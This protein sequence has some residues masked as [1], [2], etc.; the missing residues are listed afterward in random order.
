MEMV[1]GR[2]V[3]LAIP[4]SSFPFMKLFSHI[5][6][7]HFQGKNLF[8]K[9]GL[10]PQSYTTSDPNIFNN[11]TPQPAPQT[12]GNGVPEDNGPTT[13]QTLKE[14]SEANDEASEAVK[15]GEHNGVMQATMTDVQEAIEQLGRND[16]DGT[17][18]SLTLPS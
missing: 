16:R 12:N 13:L 1:G 7:R 17:V 14:D 4:S 9:I 5:R 18:A 2:L 10:F 6:L 3:L 11:S 15:K 8:G